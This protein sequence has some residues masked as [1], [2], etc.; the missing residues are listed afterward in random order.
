MLRITPKDFKN[1]S[2]VHAWHTCDGCL[3]CPI[4]G[5]HYHASKIPDFNVYTLCFKEYEGDNLEFIPEI[6]F[7]FSTVIS[8]TRL[9]TIS[10]LFFITGRD[11]CMQPKWLKDFVILYIPSTNAE[12]PDLTKK[13]P[14]CGKANLQGIMNESLSNA[15]GHD[16][17][18]ICSYLH[19]KINCC[20]VPGSMSVL[21][22]LRNYGIS[23]IMA[24]KLPWL[25]LMVQLFHQLCWSW[26]KC[27][28]RQ[29]TQV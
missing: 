22:Q 9:L 28:R 14:T 15:D 19:S 7:S 1:Q 11:L 18:I 5:T 4:I 8:D 13:I 24:P 27:Q 29:K 21:L 2:I 3:K 17:I 16:Y 25:P 6:L 26:M 10:L 12:L 23:R 20:F